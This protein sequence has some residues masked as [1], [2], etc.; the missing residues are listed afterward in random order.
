[1]EQQGFVSAPAQGALAIEGRSDLSEAGKQAVQSLEDPEAR[2][3]VEQERLVL[4]ALEGGCTLP[5]G[6][7]CYGLSGA[8]FRMEVFLAVA[9]KRGETPSS[10]GDWEAFYREMLEGPRREIEARTQALVGQLRTHLH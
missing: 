9:R 4:R 7:R 6:V 1:L 3:E 10:P 2:F 8:A 5:L